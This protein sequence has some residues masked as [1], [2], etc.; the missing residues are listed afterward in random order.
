MAQKK[1]LTLKEL[2][3]MDGKPAYWAED[4]SYGIISVDDGGRWEGIP[5]FRGRKNGA[6]FEYD[7]QAR[8]M[9][10]YAVKPP[11]LDRE[12][13]KP[14]EDCEDYSVEC[15]ANCRYRGYLKVYQDPCN[16]CYRENKWK[17]KENFC[18]ECGRPLTDEAWKMLEKRIEN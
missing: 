13:W 10:V 4:E 3:E 2:L 16:S 15:C 7:I 11:R 6:N 17:P 9:K 5:F 18:P 1:P 8:K 14:C 12:T